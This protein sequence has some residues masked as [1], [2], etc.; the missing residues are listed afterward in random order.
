[1][2][3]DLTR[4]RIAKSCASRVASRWRK[5]LRAWP[6]LGI[7][8]ELARHRRVLT[9]LSDYELRDIGLTRVEV[10]TETAFWR[11]RP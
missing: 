10:E 2:S 3:A 6:S 5:V 8:L 9:A 7:A 11:H 1:M 4:T